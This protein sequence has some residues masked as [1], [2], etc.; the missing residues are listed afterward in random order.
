MLQ[1]PTS[2]TSIRCSKLSLIVLPILLAIFGFAQNPTSDELRRGIDL[3]KH[4]DYV[5]ASETLKKV[6][7]RNKQ[8][9]EGWSYLGLSFLHQPKR[10]KEAS[11]AFEQL[12]KLRP[13]S[14]T[15]HVGLAY[16]L[17]LRNK[18]PEA[19]R[20]AGIALTADPNIAEAHYI[21]G[22]AR[23]RAGDRQEALQEAEN[24]IKLNS[25]FA[26]AYLLKSQALAYFFAPDVV[27]A[28]EQESTDD[29]KARYAQA[30]SALENYLRLNPNTVEKQTWLEQL[31]SL[32][33]FG[34]SHAKDS[35]GERIFSGKDVTTKAR[36]LKKPEPQYTDD[37]RSA[38]VSG[39]VVLRAVFAADGTV[40][41][42]LVV[43]GLPY[44]LTENSIKVARKIVFTPATVDGNPV[45]TF[46]Q[47]EYN[48]SV[49]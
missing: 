39:K 43:S 45:S 32:R 29:R 8:D 37:A 31:E 28:R 11:K 48:F 42:I 38:Q 12:L 3:Y 26:E 33:F 22:V 35:S 6:V 4:R 2:H 19:V 34:T 20:E 49:Y 7:E 23:L 24:T 14:S 30:A 27:L 40:K 5:A 13:D 18:S 41:H 16:S 25:N 9:A 21:I 10:I 46:I 47:L 1:T 36:V 44:G 17:L 15:A